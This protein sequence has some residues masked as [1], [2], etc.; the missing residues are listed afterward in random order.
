MTATPQ[1]EL[2]LDPGTQ[3]L[4][5]MRCESAIEKI[6]HDND[7]KRAGRRGIDFKVADLSV[8]R[9]SLRRKTLADLRDDQLRLDG[10]AAAEASQRVAKAIPAVARAPRRAARSVS[11][12]RST[13]VRPSLAAGPQPASRPNSTATA[14]R[15]P[16]GARNHQWGR[17]SSDRS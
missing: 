16:A 3:R 17:R 14:S 12:V 9:Q 15:A 8:N 2:T 5:D 6:H 7:I 13:S 4:D 11:I 1:L 10:P